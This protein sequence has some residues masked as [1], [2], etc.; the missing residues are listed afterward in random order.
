MIGCMFWKDHLDR[1][2]RQMGESRPAAKRRS[3][4]LAVYRNDDAIFLII[5]HSRLLSFCLTTVDS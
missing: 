4:L 3:E 1:E 2:E 5:T